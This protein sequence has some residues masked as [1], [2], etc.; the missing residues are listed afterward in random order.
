MADPIL[1]YDGVC[2]LCN[3][4]V[5]FILRRDREKVFRFTWLQ[6]ARAGRILQGHGISSGELDTV[7]VVMNCDRPE[8]R[9][10][11]RSDAVM[12]VLKEL[13]GRWRLAEFF[14]RLLPRF[15]RDAAYNAVARQR[16][17]LFGRS[18]ICRVP[19]DQDRSRFL[20]E[21]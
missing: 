6:G 13:G 15:L 21:E 2:G 10:L 17:R 19:S 11:A 9:L 4:F 7:Y 5:Q 20:D 14:L 3:W 18:E 12:F 8:E 16:Y 1:L